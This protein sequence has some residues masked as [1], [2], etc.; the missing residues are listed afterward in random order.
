MT[1]IP[2]KIQFLKTLSNLKPS[3]M[4]VVKG[5][6]DTDFKLYVTDKQ[7]TPFPIKDLSGQT[8]TIQNTDGNI[9]VTG[10]TN[11]TL[12]I[13]PTLLATINSALQSG[14]NISELVNDAGYITSFTETDPLFQASEA[15]LFVAGDKANLDNQSNINTGDETTSSIQ[16]KRPIKT[17]NGDSLEGA[18]NITIDYND[19]DNIPTTFTPST[20]THVE[21]DITDLD[22]YTQAEVDNL[23]ANIHTNAVNKVTV[24]LTE[25]INKGQAVYVSGANGTNI[26]VAKASNATEATSSKTLGLL[27]TT[28]VT[29]NTVNVVT[30]GLLT[31][32]NTNSAT[33]GDAVW[34]GTNGNLI[35]GLTNKPHAPAHLVY[36]GV[37]TRVNTNN[38]EIFVKPQN[39]FE[40]DELHDVLITN[41]QSGEVIQRDGSLWKNKQIIEDTI[42]NG[43]IDKAPSQNAVFDAFSS[44]LSNNITDYTDETSVEETDLS[45]INKAGTW[46]KTSILNIINKI[47]NRDNNWIGLNTF[48]NNTN[49]SK[50]INTTYNFLS[51]PGSSFISLKGLGNHYVNNINSAL[52][53]FGSYFNAEGQVEKAS[54]IIT[55]FTT[56]PTVLPTVNYNNIYGIRPAFSNEAG[57]TITNQYGI[58]ISSDA[59][60]TNNYGIYSGL[61]TGWNLYMEGTADNYLAG[62]VGIGT[63]S[64][65]AKLDVAGQVKISG[66]SP[67]VGKVLTSDADG[68]ASWQSSGGGSNNIFYHDSTLVVHNTGTANTLIKSIPILAN[69]W[70]NGD[71][72][73]LKI[74]L[75][76][77]QYS[78][79]QLFLNNI[80]ITQPMPQNA[81]NFFT[82]ERHLY[83]HNNNIYCAVGSE[84]KEEPNQGGLVEPINLSIDNFINIYSQ[85]WNGATA[86][87]LFFNIQKLN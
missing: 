40:L 74:G 56:Y 18:G 43:V 38:G 34:L 36:I 33:I 82:F 30:E 7:G 72:Y 8:V 63:T 84:G 81:T 71:L 32:L 52:F 25:N 69:N 60:A 37:V 61:N 22:K 10:I 17:I 39:G 3:R 86:N 14:D 12:N 55:Q 64:P 20:H 27:E 2:I 29:N 6:S 47:L 1:E 16:T 59:V 45:L 85:L 9:D 78:Q 68:L 41:P 75:N 83:I 21:A 58:Y 11:I 23:I 24:K 87:Y 70:A 13:S 51:A 31:G 4:I 48:I 19:L 62:K 35:Y 73:L 54:G 42:V 53:Q 57:A 44:K 50:T 67:G 79:T 49:F 76:S 66:G 80:V 46:L 65:A 28:G 26:L 15:S 5:D 77:T